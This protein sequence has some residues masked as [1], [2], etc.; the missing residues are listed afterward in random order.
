MA[1]DPMTVDSASDP[2]T[3][4]EGLSLFYLT[5]S[6]PADYNA[7]VGSAFD[8]SAYVSS[9]YMCTLGGCTAVA[10]NAVVPRYLNTDF[11]APAAGLVVFH[12]SADGTDGE[13]LKEVTNATNLSAYQWQVTLL[14]APA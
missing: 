7:T 14:G 6:G 3:I 11:T 5:V 4:R 12:W 2:I 8:I 1:D 13:V 9:V 10:D